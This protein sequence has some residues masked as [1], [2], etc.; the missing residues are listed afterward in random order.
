MERNRHSLRCVMHQGQVLDE[1]IDE[2]K[3]DFVASTKRCIE[4]LT[5]LT[6]MFANMDQT[7]VW[8]ESAP[9]VTINFVGSRSVSVH[10]TSTGTCCVTVQ[11]AVFCGW[12]KAQATHHF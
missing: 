8:F 9:N 11:L 7:A 6:S 1:T 5:I 10:S 4:A 3:D 2:I 12:N